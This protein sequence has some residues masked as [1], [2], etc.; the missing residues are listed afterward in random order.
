MSDK[1]NDTIY[2]AK[3]IE[4]YFAG[5]LR[6]EARHALEKAALDDP[7]L[8][9]A[10]EG[11]QQVPV[12]QW[13]SQLAALK[14]QLENT[15]APAKV[16]PMRRGSFRLMKTAAAV[17]LI[18]GGATVTWVLTRDRKDEQPKEQI[19][20]NI[21]SVKQDNPTPVVDSASSSF[22]QVSGNVNVPVNERK[23]SQAGNTDPKNKPV[24]LTDELSKPATKPQDRGIVAADEMLK[25]QS[26]TVVSVIIPE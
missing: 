20:Q 15:N 21:P 16:I 3:D 9:E 12:Q 6:P 22:N 13:K 23:N 26:Q 24:P 8:T 19:A 17:I 1:N 14:K 10:M 11:Y 4:Q 5:T 7:F 2:T 18:L 25:P